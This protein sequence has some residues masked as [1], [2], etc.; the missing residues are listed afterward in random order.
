MS[1]LFN[2]IH[3]ILRTLKTCNLQSLVRGQMNFLDLTYCNW[4]HKMARMENLAYYLFIS[5][6]ECF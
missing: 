3:Q 5:I 1:G 6:L 4:V 2:R